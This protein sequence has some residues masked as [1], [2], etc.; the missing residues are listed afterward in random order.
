MR[1]VALLLALLLLALPGRAAELTLAA[2][3]IA[4]LT[5]KPSGHPDLPATLVRRG[6]ADYAVLQGIAAVVDA[7][8]IAFQE[9]DGPLAAARVFDTTRYAFFFPAEQD[10]QRTGFAVR[11]GIPVVQNPDLADLDLRPLA[12]RSLRRGT[13][14]TV[15]VHG[16]RLR[17]LSVHL[18]A[19]CREGPL[20]GR[21]VACEDLLRQARILARWIADRDRAGEAFAIAGDFNRRLEAEDPFLA[22]LRA[23]A[24]ILRTTEGRRDVCWG[25]ERPFV[26]HILLGGAARAW[27][28]PRSFRQ[29]L[30]PDGHPNERDTLSDHCPIRITLRLGR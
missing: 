8:I 5:T 16:R 23:A 26:D 21:S 28:D 2:W 11:R 9:V 6:P 20:E 15:E 3:N 13:D 7:D 17:L 22:T 25:G 24:P 10:T 4:W 18:L 14:I 30:Y 27:F 29:V 19:G 12:R 1:L